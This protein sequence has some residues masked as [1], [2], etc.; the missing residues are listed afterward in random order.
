MV[1]TRKMIKKIVKNFLQKSSHRS[2]YEKTAQKS[3]D[4][5]LSEIQTN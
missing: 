5:R 3:I 2:F 1:G 4:G